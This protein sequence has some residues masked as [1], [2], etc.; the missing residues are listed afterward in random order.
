MNWCNKISQVAFERLTFV[1]ESG[2]KL[3]MTRRDGRAPRVQRLP[4]SV[5]GA[6]GGVM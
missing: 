6:R 5:P 3:A 1:D 4:D 2:V